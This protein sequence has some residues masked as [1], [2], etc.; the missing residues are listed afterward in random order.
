MATIGQDVDAAFF[1][2][3]YH[4][5]ATSQE[6]EGGPGRNEPGTERRRESRRA[7]QLTQRIAPGYCS[8]TP[9][10]SAW[11]DVQCYDL[12]QCG[13]SFFLDEQP[14]FDRLV[15]RFTFVEPIDLAARVIH[16][17]PVLV[18]DR[19]GIIEPGTQSAGAISTTRG[20][21]P[22]FLV[23]CQFIRQSTWRTCNGGTT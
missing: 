7:F 5:L 10:E 18:D 6:D 15:A 8:E 23:A 4:F 13:F 19:G 12:V 2:L 11:I 16:W 1:D 22:K 20:N 9:P 17:R 14:T 21:E 3:M